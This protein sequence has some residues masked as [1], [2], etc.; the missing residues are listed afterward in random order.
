MMRYGN[1]NVYGYIYI[2]SH[3]SYDI[4]NAYK[5]GKASNIPERD[6]QYAT[7]EIKRGHF[8]SVFQI[9]NE[10]MGLI[11]RLLQYE[12]CHLNIKC[13]A[14]IEFYDKKINCLIAPFLVSLGITYNELTNEEIINMVR[15]NRV[16]NTIKKINIP[17]FIQTLYL[18]AQNKTR[19]NNE[20]LSPT[21]T[22]T[23]IYTY[24][25]R[26][27]QT[28]IIEKA[29]L[30]FQ[31]NSKGLLSIPCGV[32]KTLISLW[33]TQKLNMN[34]III[35]VPNKLLLNQWKETINILFQSQNYPCLIVSG[36]I[37]TETI[38]QF[39]Q[40]E[41]KKC[42][43]ITTYSSA[44]KVYTASIE[45]RVVFNMKLNDECHHLTTSNMKMTHTTKKYIQM[46]NIPSIKQLSLTATIKQLEGSQINGYND[47]NDGGNDDGG[48]DDGGNDS[49][50]GDDGDDGGNDDGGAIIVSNDTVKYFGEIIDRKCLL[51]AIN[52][53]I[54]CDYVIQTIITDEEKLEEQLTQFYIIEETDKRLFLSA[55][56]SL[57]SIYEGHSHHLLIYS[58]NKNN[59]LKLI[60][61]IKM[62]LDNNYFDLQG[63]YY[64]NYHS[65][66]KS[67]DQQIIINK[68]EKA[69]QSIISCVYCLGE[70]WNCPLLDAVVFSENMS[71]NIR[72]VQSALRACRK[73]KLEPTKLTKI[74]LPIL[75]STDWLENNNN[76]DLRKVREIIYQ[77]GLDDETISQKIKVFN[78]EVKKHNPINT[79]Y[80]KKQNDDGDDNQPD[81]FGDYNEELTQQLRLKTMSRTTLGTSYQKAVKIIADKNVRS[82]EEYFKLCEK[83][84]RLP[85]EPEIIYATQFTGWIDYFSI[86]RTFYDMETCIEKVGK[87]L[88]AQPRIKYGLLNL[89]DICSELCK[90]DPLFP[91][92]GLW[93][94]YYDV[95]DL[96]NI[97]II[98]NKKKRKI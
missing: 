43:V 50:D 96:Q 55:Y 82:K 39:L 28:I 52:E 58:N 67:K 76:T 17:L 91:P 94:E 41:N 79:K 69:K 30:Y 90:I 34:T 9:A 87:Y 38:K 83:D 7:G 74:I 86:Q 88:D 53:N 65:E 89:A 42:I 40:T 68:F 26:N 31:A 46:L 93:V 57:K 6:A 35:G 44:H 4:Y 10:K 21:P 12:F 85:R 62:L 73:N 66:M 25:P 64:S 27:Y 95:K 92:N 78:I 24:T 16:K 80:E 29:E 2:R 71:S 15:C 47:S 18:I 61:Y 13:D 81:N 22:L 51:W 56:A 75:N 33:I 77:M 63:F 3:E 98:A 36:G 49:N 97:I 72:I 70:G 60:Q 19:A 48:N 32:G 14:G 20:N 37:N 84:N 5:M 1:E 8:I 54:I 23:P 45:T 11:E 59:S